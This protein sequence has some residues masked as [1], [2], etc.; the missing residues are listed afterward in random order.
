MPRHRDAPLLR[1]RRYRRAAWRQG[2]LLRS[3]YSLCWTVHSNI[4]VLL[5]CRNESLA[6]LSTPLQTHGTPFSNNLDVFLQ[7]NY[8]EIAF[9][10]F[11]AVCIKV[12]CSSFYFSD[13]IFTF[14]FSGQCTPTTTATINLCFIGLNYSKSEL[15]HQSERM[16]VFHKHFAVCVILLSD[17]EL[18]MQV[19]AGWSLLV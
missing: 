9:R 15:M 12:R 1:I 11:I 14:Q 16:L 2:L 17:Y 5:M 7:T 3:C 18:W 6:H 10:L 13:F 19:D 8:I 4:G